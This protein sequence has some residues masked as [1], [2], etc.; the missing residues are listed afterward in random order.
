MHQDDHKEHQHSHSPHAHAENQHDSHN[1]QHAVSV[2]ADSQKRVAWVLTLTGSY[3]VIQVI[4]GLWSGSL[5]LLADAGHMLSDS[6]ALLLAFIAFRLANKPADAK[7]SFGYGR[8]QILAAFVNGLS[9]FLI[10]FWITFEAVKRIN[11][12]GDILAGPM[13]WIA[14]IGLCVNIAG[15]VILQRGNQDNVNLRG[16]LLH[17][18]GDLL[19]SVAAIVAALVIM[20]TGWM[21]IDPILAVFVALLILRSAWQLVTSAAHIL[22]EGTPQGLTL[23]Q[24][25]QSLLALD[26]VEAVHHLHVWAITQEERMASIHIVKSQEVEGDQL[27][28]AVQALM[29]DAFQISHCTVQIEQ[30]ACQSPEH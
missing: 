11:A 27:L 25:A 18:L 4:G 2:T 22:L 12:P 15:F 17:V 9:L 23:D 28:N 1:H 10:A 30:A 13:L 20:L 6:L 24:I 3:T 14:V 5:A 16:A 29:L 8:F 19:G 26:G 21:P 7:R